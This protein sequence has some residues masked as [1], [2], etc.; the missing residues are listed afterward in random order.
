VQVEFGPAL[1]DLPDRE[2]Y[3]RYDPP[4][5]LG[6]PDA[7]AHPNQGSFPIQLASPEFGRVSK[8]GPSGNTYPF[9]MFAREADL[10]EVPFIGAY[11]VYARDTPVASDAPLPSKPLSDETGHWLYEMNSVSMDSAFAEDTDTTDDYDPNAL[12]GEMREQIGRFCPVRLSRPP[13]STAPRVDDFAVSGDVIS[14]PLRHPIATPVYPVAY[15][16]RES[17][18]NFRYRYRWAA[19]LFEQFTIRSPNDDFLPNVAPRLYKT[20]AGALITPAPEA[21]SN[22]GSVAGDTDSPDPQVRYSEDLQPID[23]LVNINTA[24]WKVLAAL[25]MV[26][27][28]DGRVDVQ[29]NA[30]LAKAIVY[31]RDVHDGYKANGKDRKLYPH[32]PFKSLF[33]LNEVWDS[34]PAGARLRDPTKYPGNPREY[35]FRNGF[36]TIDFAAQA[37][38]APGGNEG[39]LSAN[40][41]RSD[42]EKQYLVLN[43]ISNLIT[44][45]SDS[46]TCY[47]FVMGVAHDGAADAE[48]KVQR[49]VAFIADRSGVRPLRPVVRTMFFNNQ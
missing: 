10:L 47:V 21:V 49:R 9:G 44:T 28:A 25:P 40:D 15:E 6:S 43:R 42:L 27:G 4:V 7:K 32:G 45:R 13:G 3:E 19:D 48:I 33:E 17:E 24:P 29:R 14:S 2:P 38:Q 16:T 41:A 1:G 39:E 12:L 30:E 5:K 11:T 34:R 46:F 22:S 8:L 26:L 36:G 35:S 18:P 37:G 20:P 31:F 23:G